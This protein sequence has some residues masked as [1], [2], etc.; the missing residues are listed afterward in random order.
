LGSGSDLQGF[1]PIEFTLILQITYERDF[2]KEDLA[3]L[4]QAAKK[5]ADK[6]I[7]KKKRKPTTDSASLH[8]SHVFG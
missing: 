1:N 3:A 5:N 6:K 7:T 8:L 2:Y 4:K